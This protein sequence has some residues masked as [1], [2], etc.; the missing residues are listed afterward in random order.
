MDEKTY[1]H[2]QPFKVV[3]GVISAVL[4]VVIIFLLTSIDGHL[5]ERSLGIA[6]QE[7]TFVD[8]DVSYKSVSCGSN[9]ANGTGTAISVAQTGRLSFSAL[10]SNLTAVYIC[11][12]ASSC[13]KASSTIAISATTS[14]DMPISYFQEDGYIGGYSCV[15]DGATSTITVQEAL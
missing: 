9:G 5:K 1:N 10:N 7:P 13:V 2:L 12:A 8:T 3:I 11:R 6:A 14:L 15:S 4:G